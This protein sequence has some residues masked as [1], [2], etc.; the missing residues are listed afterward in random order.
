MRACIGVDH[1]GMPPAG[2]LGANF[3]YVSKKSYTVVAMMSF[4]R[5]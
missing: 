5:A 4:S 1:A 3:E 2:D